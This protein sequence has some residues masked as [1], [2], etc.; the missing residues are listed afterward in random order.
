MFLDDLQWADSATLDLL[1]TLMAKRSMRH[2][3]VIGAY[4]DNEVSSAH[5]LL[6]SLSEIAKSGAKVS[7]I[8]LGALDIF[9]LT[10]F[11]ADT[12]K[13][14]V[15]QVKPL[16]ELI[17]SKT[18]GNPFFVIQFLKS[19]YQENLLEF[20]YDRGQWIFDLDRIYLQDMTDNVVTLM[21]G[22]IRNLVTHAQDVTKLAAC[23]GNSFDLATLAIVNKKSVRQTA[24]DLWPAVQ[25]GL[26][27]PLEDLNEYMREDDQASMPK[28]AYRFL[29]DRVQQAAYTLIPDEQKKAVHLKVG[30]LMW[31]HSNEA[32]L[33]ENLFDIVN[34]LNI[35][36]ELITDPANR[37]ELARLNLSAG[38]KAKLSTAYRPAL[39]YYQ[40][41]LSLLGGQGWSS[42][43]DLSFAL[44]RDL[45][46]CEYLCGNFEQA[47]EDFDLLLRQARTKLEKAEIHNLRIIQ[48]ENMAKY[49]EAVQSGQA[50]LEP[51]GL[52][53]PETDAEKK[54]ALE[55]EMDLIWASLGD[56]QIEE[57]AQLPVMTQPEMKMSMKLL[58]TVWTP[59]YI[60]GDVYLPALLSATMVRLSLAYGNSEESAYAYMTHGITVGSVLGDYK[61]GYEFGKLA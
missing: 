26:I 48:H 25:E 49:A 60:A 12:L 54:L 32:D 8:S 33:E 22:K 17:L 42:Y 14:E 18:N 27:L 45:A 23:I 1:E 41:G 53:L 36:A 9:H 6:L 24:T 30:Q 51:F 2:L 56:K 21:A 31:Q 20:D 3:L 34:H 5:P 39:T 43:Y 52:H 11:V 29:H 61:A 46:E 13:S 19:L 55:A 50:G 35:G 15:D 10:Q 58:M 16:A 47:E 37:I 38:Q 57:L 44:Y 7:H 40:M 59:A 4:R 28:L